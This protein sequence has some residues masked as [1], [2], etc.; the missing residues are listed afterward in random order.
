LLD[1]VVGEG[2]GG[3]ERVDILELIEEGYILNGVVVELQHEE[4]GKVFD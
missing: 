2:D 3:N 4:C 1:L